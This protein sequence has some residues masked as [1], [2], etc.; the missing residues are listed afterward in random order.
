MFILR[1]LNSLLLI[2]LLFLSTTRLRTIFLPRKIFSPFL[3][4]P[5]LRVKSPPPLLYPLRCHLDDDMG[6]TMGSVDGLILGRAEA[7]FLGSTAM[8]ISMLFSVNS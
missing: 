4:L 7:H 8:R 1:F 2:S 3:P 5:R 6:R